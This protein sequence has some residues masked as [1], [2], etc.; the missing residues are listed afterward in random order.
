MGIKNFKS[1]PVQDLCSGVMTK[2]TLS[3]LPKELHRTALKKIQILRA[4][5]DLSD[6]G[7]F[8][9]LRLEKLKGQRS[10]EYSI[11]INIQYRIF[12]KLDGRDCFDVNIEDYH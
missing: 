7:N 2:K 12:F 6:I 1:Q 3:L 9:G 11:R 8:P 4:A 5:K 10:S